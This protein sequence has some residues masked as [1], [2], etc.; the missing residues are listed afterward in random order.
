MK[1]Y[2][3]SLLLL[4]LLLFSVSCHQKKIVH[5]PV[6]PTSPAPTLSTGLNETQKEQ[7]DK[8]FP[9]ITDHVIDPYQELR[10]KGLSVKGRFYKDLNQ[11]GVPELFLSY[12]SGS[13]GSEYVMYRITKKGYDFLGYISF[14]YFQL[15]STKH[16][17]YFD[18]QTFVRS[19]TE[20]D[21]V[22]VGGL[23]KD[24]YD[25][26]KYR[27]ISRIDYVYNENKVDS[28]FIPDQIDVT[29]MLSS[30]WSP[31]DDDKYRRMIK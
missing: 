19:Y 30:L 6:T 20:E 27:N 21:G 11:D 8:G 10:E 9:F 28:V 5:V 17:G 24:T 25:G 2:F 23:Y 16:N 3:V 15:L 26:N 4:M 13:A 18:I 14:L 31:K 1:K 12:D 22:Y 29:L 7:I